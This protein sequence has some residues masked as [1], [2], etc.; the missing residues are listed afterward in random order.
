MRKHI[1]VLLFIILTLSLSVQAFAVEHK[2]DE[3]AL[4]GIN[5][6]IYSNTKTGMQ[7][8]PV[9]KD[10]VLYLVKGLTFT[11]EKSATTSDKKIVSVSK[12]K[13]TGKKNGTTILTLD[14][15]TYNAKVITPKKSTTKTQKGSVGDVISLKLLDQDN[16]DL[17]DLNVAWQSS[18]QNVAQVDKGE[19]HLVG[20]G[21][22]SIYAYLEGKKY[23]F[24]VSSA[25]KDGATIIYNAAVGSTVNL[26]TVTGQKVTNV[27]TASSIVSISGVKVKVLSP[28]LAVLGVTTKKGD[29]IVKLY[30]ESATRASDS[31][32]TVNNKKN[33]LTLAV[34]D[35][36]YLSFPGVHQIPIWTSSNKK[37]A[38]VDEYG[39]VHALKVG[40]STLSA[41]VAGKNYKVYLTVSGTAKP[42]DTT[43]GKAKAICVVDSANGVAG[44]T[45]WIDPEGQS[46]DEDPTIRYFN[47]TFDSQGGTPVATQTIRSGYTCTKPEDPTREGYMFDY[48]SEQ[49][50][51]YNFASAVRSHI[52]L[53]ANWIHIKGHLFIDTNGDGT[54]DTQ[55]PVS[56]DGKII[57]DLPTDSNGRTITEVVV[58]Q[59]D[60]EDKT[61]NLVVDKITDEDVNKQDTKTETK[62]ID[63]NPNVDFIKV[64]TTG[65]G[66]A[67][68][69]VKVD[70]STGK[71]I[72]DLP[73]DDEGKTVDKITYTDDDGNKQTVDLNKDTIPTEVIS[74]KTTVTPVD[75]KPTYVVAFV[76]NGGTA[77]PA[78]NITSG[79][80]ATRPTD[81]EK[82]YSL[83]NGWKLNG[84]LYDFSRPVTSDIILVADWQTIRGHLYVDMNGDNQID[85]RIPISETGAVIGA[86]PRDSKGTV[87]EYITI[88]DK[89]G[90]KTV[91]VLADGNI[92]ADL[93]KDSQN[94]NCPGRPSTAE[95][96]DAHRMVFTVDFNT[97]G[98]TEIPDQHV[99]EGDLV[100][101]PDVP[102][103]V[104]GNVEY[105]FCDWVLYG[106]SYDFE[107]PV[108][109]DLNLR[110]TWRQATGEVFI[111]NSDG[112]KT[113]IPFAEDATINEDYF[114]IPA[115]DGYV[116]LGPG[117][118]YD[119]YHFEGW[120]FTGTDGLEHRYYPKSDLLEEGTELRPKFVK[121][122]YVVTFDANG[123]TNLS[124][125]RKQ[126]RYGETYGKLP[127]VEMSGKDFVG[128]Y[129][130]PEGGEHVLE[131]SLMNKETNHTLYAHF[132]DK[133]YDITFDSKG[134]N[135]INKQHVVY[136]AAIGNLPMP[137][138]YGHIFD[139]WYYGDTKITSDTVYT[140]TTDIKV[141]AHW[142]EKMVNVVFDPAGGNMEETTTKKAYNAEIG[143]LPIPEKLGYTFTGWYTA[144]SGG[145]LV[146]SS[147]KIA[148]DDILNLY[149]RYT[150]NSYKVTFNDGSSSA[151]IIKQLTLKYGDNIL[152]NAEIDDPTRANYTFNGWYLPDNTPLTA[153]TKM[154]ASNL[155]ISAKWTACKY[156]V[157]FDSQGGTLTNSAQLTREITYLQPYGELPEV[158]RNHYKFE[159]WFTVPDGSVG[160]L[161]SKDTP[162]T[163]S[164]DSIAYAH[165]TP[166]TYKLTYR[167]GRGKD[168]IVRSLLFDEEFGTLPTVEEEGYT[169]KGWYYGQDA[170]SNKVTSA[171][172]MPD[173]DLVVYALWQTNDY[174]IT[175]DA[176][177]GTINGLATTDKVVTFGSAFGTL[178]TPEQEGFEFVKYTGPENETV[179]AE[180]IMSYGRPITLKANW[181]P[182]KYTVTYKDQNGND[183]DVDPKT[184]TYHAAY[185]ILYEPPEIEGKSFLGWN[186][187]A[188]GTG[189]SVSDS[190][191]VTIAMNHVLYASFGTKAYTIT[192]DSQGGT[193]VAPWKREFEATF[194][195]L[196]TPV[197]AGYV[198][199][200]WYYGNNK[201]K[202]TD[203]TPAQNIQLVARWTPATNTKYTVNYYKMELDG[204][205][206][207]LFDTKY[208]YG[209]TESVVTPVADD[210]DGFQTP[211]NETVQIKADGSTVVD[212]KYNRRK[213]TFTLNRATGCDTS[214][215]TP[216]GEYYFGTEITLKAEPSDGYDWH[217]WS[218]NVSDKTTTF[219][220]PNKDVTV[221]PVVSLHEYT[222]SYIL[223][224][225]SIN[226]NKTTYTSE[227]NTFSIPKPT[228]DEYEFVGWTGSNGEVPE[229]DLTIEKGTSG[230]LIFTANWRKELVTYTVK[231]YFMSLDG[232]TYDLGEEKSYT[233]EIKSEV[234]PEVKPT[235][236]FT[237]PEK[238]TKKINDNTTTIE[239]YYTRNQHRFTL[240]EVDGCTVSGV[241]GV[242]YYGK[243]INITATPKY[244]YEWKKWS[245]GEVNASI[246]VDMPDEDI[247]YTPIVALHEYPIT[248]E[249]QGGTISGQK[250]SYNAETGAFVLPE[251][252]RRGYAFLGWTGYNG[253][254]PQKEVIV[255]AGT[256]EDLTFT[257]NWSEINYSITYDLGIGGVLDSPVNEYNINTASFTLGTP[258]RPGCEF[259]GWTGPNGTVP[260]TTVMVAKGTTG[261]LTYKA[262]WN[263]TPYTIS[264]ELNEGTLT[265]PVTDYS[266]DTETFTLAIPKRNGYNFTGWTGSNGTVPQKTVTIEQG[267]TG[268]KSYTANWELA[269]Y[270]I[271]YELGGG[272]LIGQKTEYSYNTDSFTLP[273]P[274][275]NGNTFLGWTGSN[276]S[277]PQKIVTV[278]TGT[279]GDLGYTAVW[280]SDVQTL[281]ILKIE[282]ELW[283][284]VASSTIN[285]GNVSEKVEEITYKIEPGQV[286]RIYGN[287]QAKLGLY[288]RET[289]GTITNGG[290]HYIVEDGATGVEFVMPDNSLSLQLVNNA[291][292]DYCVVVDAGEVELNAIYAHTFTIK[293]SSTE[294]W[295][296][297]KSTVNFG[298]TSETVSNKT[299]TV[300]QGENIYIYGNDLTLRGLDLKE[301][302]GTITNGHEQ[303]IDDATGVKLM[304]PNDDVELTLDGEGDNYVV[305]VTKGEVAIEA[306]DTKV[307]TVGELSGPWANSNLSV[308]GN[309]QQLSAAT[310]IIAPGDIVKIT[311][312]NNTVKDV[313][314]HC[315]GGI[316][317]NFEDGTKIGTT[318]GIQFIMPE[319]SVGLN[320]TG[321]DSAY[322]VTATHGEVALD[323]IS[324]QL[325]TVTNVD[326]TYWAGNS[327]VIEY[328]NDVERISTTTYEIEPG[329]TVRI[330]GNDKTTREL[331]G[332]ENGGKVSNI[333]GDRGPSK[334]VQFTMPAESVSLELGYGKLNDACDEGYLVTVKEGSIPVNIITQTLT[335]TKVNSSYWGGE[336]SLIEY[337]NTSD[338]IS[339]RSYEIPVGDTVKLYGNNNTERGLYL[340]ETEGLI[341]NGT[342]WKTPN[343]N[344]GNYGATF[345]MPDSE[346][347]LGLSYYG[348][349]Y[350]VCADEGIVR[351]D[352]VDSKRVAPDET[353]THHLNFNYVNND[354]WG[355]IL[356]G[357]DWKDV[358]TDTE[359]DLPVG[360][361]VTVYGNNTIVR[362]IQIYNNGTSIVSSLGNNGKAK[363]FEFTIPTHDVSLSLDYDPETNAYVVNV[364]NSDIECAEFQKTVQ[365]LTIS[366]YDPF[367]W[368]GTDSTVGYGTTESKLTQT[369]YAIPVGETVSL[370]G[371]EHVIR[372][373]FVYGDESHTSTW[374]SLGTGGGVKFT[375]PNRSIVLNLSKDPETEGYRAKT[376]TSAIKFEKLTGNERIPTY[377]LTIS[378]LDTSYW[379]GTDSTISYGD[380]I[381]IVTNGT[382]QIPVG[383]EVKIYTNN[384]APYQF[385]VQDSKHS[386]VTTLQTES[387]PGI[388]F[389]MPNS[390]V[391]LQLRYPTGN[392]YDYGIRNSEKNIELKPI[393]DQ[394]LLISGFNSSYWGNPHI[395]V[396]G[397]DYGTVTT[398]GYSIPANAL[399]Q[400]CGSACNSECKVRNTGSGTVRALG[401]NVGTSWETY[402]TNNSLSNYGIQF[403]MPSTPLDLQLTSDYYQSVVVKSGSINLDAITCSDIGTCLYLMDQ[404][405]SQTKVYV[406]DTNVGTLSNSWTRFN[407]APGDKIKL[408]YKEEALSVSDTYFYNFGGANVYYK[409]TNITNSNRNGDQTYAA[410]T[411]TMPK[412][413]VVLKAWCYN[414][415]H[416][417]LYCP[418]RRCMMAR[419]SPR[420]RNRLGMC[421][422]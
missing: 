421:R 286:V 287:N 301:D 239:Y 125:S 258:T 396:D 293:N 378:N 202:E 247:E 37:V 356:I 274:T 205:N 296:S 254:V 416:Y 216:S 181:A 52:T 297:T 69:L 104:L 120:F 63:E 22:A 235:V 368:G 395:Y 376:N 133:G 154:P 38:I 359:L 244:G 18:N 344:T 41:K 209:T 164:T 66:E 4:L 91:V 176:N 36:E 403:L 168:D 345:T 173:R 137:E 17:S 249:L 252:T 223:D 171:D 316:I 71:V 379:G 188:D 334:G 415:R 215:S 167:V 417:M 84:V 100:D 302:G 227:T 283:G 111:I 214:A 354:I 340:S 288:V 292:N 330:Y 62:V 265:K 5:N 348:N 360:T 269:V 322:N 291:Y 307:F 194:G 61:I 88:T 130:E 300:D 204:I 78:Q 208:F 374:G 220:M 230:D 64:D 207:K 402:Y 284:N 321:T 411:F 13:F 87:V 94:I 50:N 346:L 391:S 28:G 31:R 20:K 113:K 77:I 199:D 75:E 169:F 401:K 210:I 380:K 186:T 90:N 200:G 26:N 74:G 329:E 383:E 122:Y 33:Y 246:T 107:T 155:I 312:A 106:N 420:L 257:A 229:K 412:G 319:D 57:G 418:M 355:N 282:N 324:S 166:N 343:T 197:K 105:T 109:Q 127:T 213:Y 54:N 337:D 12:L 40:T 44:K 271:S 129:T 211:A 142:T 400:I 260:Q 165:W 55:L 115:P 140:Y 121:N 351:L 397:V 276:G 261:D 35:S 39:V 193:T 333:P 141:E 306:P 375:M 191:I 163:Q 236:G 232:S 143:D 309:V 147:Y 422:L 123:G 228:R 42:S 310:Y 240:N 149:A 159:G 98:G 405:S 93:I 255:E 32:I 217:K 175:I 172:K 34:G 406:N 139:G 386:S 108:V 370:F 24:K 187:K 372:D 184:V 92:T 6:E 82:D 10:N 419:R 326:S 59:D 231:H 81:P 275:K 47:V 21:S 320:L 323:V 68:T 392:Y 124:T 112:T 361:T 377:T 408:V 29:C 266:V 201:V 177:G 2:V 410:Y 53:T 393:N 135:T 398:R 331:W 279:T 116:T 51:K 267:T 384:H 414:S 409:D 212:Y 277:E 23:T 413:I 224:N 15:T 352:P 298:A 128:W 58:K 335:I 27:T 19:V 278:D 338:K 89:Y 218:N 96:I 67:D 156:R 259:R 49:G 46:H 48:W 303:H 262:N 295:G 95:E 80:T 151:T 233:V 30:G 399:V 353:V 263:T 3:P 289:G 256:A 73:K 339:K 221:S 148:T 350:L 404:K 245:N 318:R 315:D 103:R 242:Y 146:T 270:S 25:F 294:Y 110:A 196:P 83:F 180:T 385:Y 253:N 381:S 97:D 407:P 178:P 16:N 102:E 192:F 313:Y 264:Y 327:S 373:I 65:D 185:G 390:D 304:M 362:D 387:I 43:E 314:A 190:D 114:V 174:R 371:N 76:T 237:S 357:N 183:Y 251:P 219:T 325:L 341:L 225:G 311:E 369:T 342:G 382:Y 273:T 7:A 153:S 157:T 158:T 203:T 198:L 136:N 248:Y 14:G 60:G 117:E 388:K 336:D 160:T 118:T 45:V 347:A 389:T 268:D 101:K 332:K 162:Y 70:T 317:T 131:G 364:N 250:T 358:T 152:N 366:S 179:T 182:R 56:D 394:T 365:M 226:G 308:N 134:G 79:K 138:R 285:Y 11:T 234:T 126:V 195:S 86:L 170:S 1:S 189:L 328:G 272:V 150:I 99:K 72:G 85:T 206:Y 8:T 132:T 9:L 144:P 363:G 119:D 238:I 305:T 349:G 299:Y 290:S 243:K 161:I 241:S 367:R 145:T 281:R 222:I 280:K